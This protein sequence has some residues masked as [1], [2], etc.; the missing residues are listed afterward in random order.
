MVG[1][2]I[3]Y[4]PGV[5]QKSGEHEMESESLGGGPKMVDC[6]GFDPRKGARVDV[7]HPHFPEWRFT[8]SFSPKGV[9]VGFAAEPA[10]LPPPRMVGFFWMTGEEQRAIGLRSDDLRPWSRETEHRGDRVIV[11]FTDPPPSPNP[12]VHEGEHLTARTMRRFPIGEIQRTAERAYVDA[13][14][15]QSR[16]RWLSRPD[17]DRLQRW[18][19]VFDSVRRPGRR[20]RDDAAY[21]AV[22]ERYVSLLGAGR[23]IA[24]LAEELSYSPSRV[25][26]LVYEAR[27][28]GLLTAT[29][30]GAEGGELTAKALALLTDT[31]DEERD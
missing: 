23:A 22:A 10:E 28:R 14:R 1:R 30:R 27:R 2:G 6:S 20:G 4:C 24:L 15:K 9:P 8:V 5:P 26:D 25:R 13:L 18:V 21:A 11:R 19:A 3:G 17:D 31:E 16:L 7:I 12:C 29:R